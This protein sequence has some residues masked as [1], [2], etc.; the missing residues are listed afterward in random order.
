[1]N[2]IPDRLAD[3]DVSGGTVKRTLPLR[4][5]AGDAIITA[6][7]TIVVQTTDEQLV[8]TLLPGQ[9][10]L[11]VF[12]DAAA[13]TTVLPFGFESSSS[14]G[15]IWAINFYLLYGVPGTAYTLR[16]RYRTASQPT[17]DR[18]DELYRVIAVA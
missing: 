13:S 11:Q 10:K 3:H 2:H 18:Y 15:D 16:L 12:G 1:M 7:L 4:L 5:D 9:Q 14:T 6:S 17:R 8:E